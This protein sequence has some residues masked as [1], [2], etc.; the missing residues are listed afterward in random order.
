V[1][2]PS[3]RRI[4]CNIDAAF[5]SNN[6]HIGFGICIRDQTCDFIRAKTKSVE[7]RCESHVGEVLG[8]LST[9]RWVHELDLGPVDFALDSKLVVDSF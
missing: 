5:P 1:E 7:K 6:N 4:K 9:L 3:P 8:F 2:K